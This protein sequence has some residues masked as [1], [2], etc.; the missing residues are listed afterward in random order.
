MNFTRCDAYRGQRAE[1]AGQNFDPPAEPSKEYFTI[2]FLTQIY[3]F[4]TITA[5]NRVFVYKYNSPPLPEVPLPDPQLNGSDGN[6]AGAIGVSLLLGL[7]II[8]AVFV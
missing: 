6:S 1:C 7:A 3:D 2:Y 5:Q 4:T 8:Q